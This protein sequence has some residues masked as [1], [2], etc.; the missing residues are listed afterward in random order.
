MAANNILIAGSYPSAAAPIS[1]ICSTRSEWQPLYLGVWVKLISLLLIDQGSLIRV[2][3]LFEVCF[4]VRKGAA[5]CMCRIG[6]GEPCFRS[7][8]AAMKVIGNAPKQETGRWLNNRSENSHQPFRRRE[9]AMLRFRQM[10][11]LQKFAAVHSSVH[12][13]FNK[14]R[15]LY[16]RDNFKLNRSAALAEWRQLCFGYVPAY[17]V[18]LKLVQIRLTA[19]PLHQNILLKTSILG[20]VVR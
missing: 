9:R 5:A 10:R 16:L 17:R 19:P 8:G 18:I 1:V 12:N 2:T 13:H 6:S 20:C 3:L 4:A 11:C 15:H 14:E 7:Y